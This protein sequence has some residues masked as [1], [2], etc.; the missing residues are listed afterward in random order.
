M[1]YVDTSVIVKL[2]IREE[3]S[4]KASTWLQK[5]NE[6]V[7]LTSLHEL[8]F[9]NAIHLKRFRAEISPDEIRLLRSRFEEHESSGIYYR[10]QL[11]WPVIFSHAVDLSKKHTASIGSRSLDILHVAAALSIKADRFLTL[12]DRQTSLAALAGLKISNINE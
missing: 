12:D 6:A 11:D 1:V 8:E 7:P 9:I 3:F 10:P 2:Y 5:N 4:R